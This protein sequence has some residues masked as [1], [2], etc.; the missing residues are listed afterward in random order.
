[1]LNIAENIHPYEVTSRGT[2]ISYIPLKFQS[3]WFGH[4]CSSKVKGVEENWKAILD[5]LYVFQINIDYDMYCLW[6]TPHRTL[7]D[8]DFSF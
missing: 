1:M 7:N 5:F 4:S 6:D 2:F 8:L 3:T